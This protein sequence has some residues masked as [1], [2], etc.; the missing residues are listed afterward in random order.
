M[1]T[2]VEVIRLWVINHLDEI[3][4]I[5]MFQ[6]FHDKY[7]KIKQVHLLNYCRDTKQYLKQR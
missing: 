6:H 7:L 4:Y 3:N 1:S 2:H 5:R